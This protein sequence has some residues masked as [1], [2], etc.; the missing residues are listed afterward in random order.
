MKGCKASSV[1]LTCTVTLL[2]PLGKSHIVLRSYRT[3]DGRGAALAIGRGTEFVVAGQKNYA[4]HLAWFGIA[5]ALALQAN[6][7]QLYSGQFAL[8]QIRTYGIDVANAPIPSRAIVDQ[9]ERLVGGITFTVAGPYG[10]RQFHPGTIPRQGLPK[11]AEFSYNGRSTGTETFAVRAARGNVTPGSTTV[12][13]SPRGSGTPA[14]FVAYNPAGSPGL[15]TVAEFDS[16]AIG[17]ATPLAQA[18]IPSSN[19]SVSPPFGV[20]SSGNFWAGGTGD[21]SISHYSN[22]GKLLGS[23]TL[24]ATTTGA[25]FD[26]SG[27]LYEIVG[28]QGVSSYPCNTESSAMNEYAAGSNATV[29]V[30]SV[31][32]GGGCNIGTLV[33]VDGLGDVWIASNVSEGQEGGYAIA[34]YAPNASGNATPVFSTERQED[35]DTDLDGFATDSKGNA[36]VMFGGE[37]HTYGPSPRSIPK[38][39]EHSITT[40]LALD[41]GGDLYIAAT[42][43]S[44]SSPSQGIP[45]ILEYPPG[46]GKPMRV[47]TGS[48]TGLKDAQIRNMAVLP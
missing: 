27:N 6:P 33:S 42:Q 3:S 9:N 30:R 45:E 28:T 5:K 18:S 10:K 31:N 46:S 37:V 26:K 35:F 13:L 23:I 39:P 20:D 34:E 36:Y 24:A 38:A 43:T 8:A 44:A 19:T 25:T 15:F 22:K 14:I 48:N 29:L 2:A 16:S 17:N 11:F 47:I 7:S 41:S 40:S 32:L 12:T 4:T 21:N 1:G